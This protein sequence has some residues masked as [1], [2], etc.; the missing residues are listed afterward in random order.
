MTST[1]STRRNPTN[2]ESNKKKRRQTKANAPLNSTAAL[3]RERDTN[4]AQTEAELVDDEDNRTPED[5][6][7]GNS[8]KQD[9]S[10]QSTVFQSRFVGLDINTFEQQLD[11]WTLVS[12][13]EAI[14]SQDSRRSTAHKDIKDLVQVV[15]M[16]FEKRI[17]MIALMAGVPEVVIW[18]LV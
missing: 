10:K 11:N 15:Q 12:L 3:S 17:L 9:K 14:V 2:G 6:P 1:R 4:P 13:Q 8:T 7:D 18:N 5:P 16:E